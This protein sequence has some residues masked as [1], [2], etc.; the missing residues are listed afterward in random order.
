MLE[1]D[2]PTASDSD[3]EDSLAMALNVLLA[4]KSIGKVGSPDLV[5]GSV[6]DQGVEQDLWFAQCDKNILMQAV[7]VH[8]DSVSD[9]MMQAEGV[10]R[11]R[12]AVL[13][14]SE[15]VITPAQR[16]GKKSWAEVTQRGHS[17]P[18]GQELVKSVSKG[19]E[20]DRG[21]TKRSGGKT[22]P[23]SRRK[24]TL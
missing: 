17:G 3:V 4:D 14:D 16:T 12:A 18:K 8:R 23:G 21:V 13:S 6:V 7:E 20:R 2:T 15:D 5:L 19:G 22:V 1:E 24:T 10:S 11:K 9:D